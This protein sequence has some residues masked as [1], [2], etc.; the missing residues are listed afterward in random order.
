[1]I[2]TYVINVRA[3]EEDAVFEKYFVRMPKER[4][5][6]IRRMKHS[7]DR[8]R[9][10]GAGI[11]LARGLLAYGIDLEDVKIAQD[12]NGKPYL[13]DIRTGKRDLYRGIHFNLSHAGDYAAAAFGKVPVGV[14]IE[15]RRKFNEGVIRRFHE[16]ERKAFAACENETE[17]EDLFLKCWTVKESAAK[18][19]GLGIR[20]PFD[21][22]CRRDNG[23][24]EV[25]WKEHLWEYALREFEFWETD[26]MRTQEHTA[27]GTKYRVAVCAQT[28]E[29]HVFEELHDEEI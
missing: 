5:E 29:E 14:D 3:L 25:R 7:K 13:A 15:R 10:L 21:S 24:V 17:R 16:E 18:V 11:L 27:N 26:G 2:R 6:K 8:E 4:R 19:S 9:S 20:L 23:H 28:R 12:G 1:M 22:I